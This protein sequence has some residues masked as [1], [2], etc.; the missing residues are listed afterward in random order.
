MLSASANKLSRL[1]E[2]AEE[3]AALIMEELDPERLGYIE[4][5]QLETL[6]LQKDTYLN[7]S[8]ALSYTSQAL[9]QNLQGLRGKSRI[10]R[11]SSD[12][13]YIMQENWK[14]IWVLS[15]WIMIMIGLFLWKFFQYKQKDAFHVMGYCLLTAKGAAETL[16]FNMALI[17]F[18]VCRNTITWLRSTRLS[19]FVPFDDNINFHKTIAGAIV[20]AVILHIGDHLA[21]DFPRIVRATEY[22]YNRYL[23]HYFQTKQPT[24]FDLVKG[25]EGITGILMVILMIISFTLATRWFRRNLVKLPKPFDRLTGFN[26]FW[27]SHHLFVIVYILLI[28]HGIFLYFAKPWYVRTVSLHD[29]K[30]SNC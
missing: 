26:A 24:Y 16:K 9:S 10:H 23:F 18:P 2:Q 25:P 12:F 29:S 14:R 13:V 6:L 1:K 19:Y 30:L 27:Y 5:W 7:Y 11:M 4:L 21:C 28:L 20:V 3:Y 22:D 17:L 8:Q 15:L